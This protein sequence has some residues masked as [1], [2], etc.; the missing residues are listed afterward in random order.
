[1]Y[2]NVPEIETAIANLAAAH[3]TITE[4][5]ALPETSF[6]GKTIHC[7]RI[8]SNAADAADG[9]LF[10][11]GQHAREWVPPEIALALVADL[12]DAYAGNH[13][14]TYGGKSY[15]AAEVKAIVETVN[16]FAVPCS[17]PDGRE[18]TMAVPDFFHTNWRPNRN[19]SYHAD[20]SCHGVDLNRNYDVAFDLGKY[21]LDINAVTANTSDKPC[22]PADVYQGPSPFSEPE[23]RN[24][25]WLLDLYPRLRWLIDVHGY[26]GEIYY[27]WGLDQN[28]SDDAAMNW[29][30][31]AFDGQRGGEN[32]AYR[33]YISSGD[34][35]THVLLANHL[36]DGMEPVRGISY[37]VTQSFTFYP[38]CG[39]AQD[40]AWSRHFLGMKRVESFTIEIESS[41]FQPPLAEKDEVV[42]EVV[43]G[44]INFCLGIVCGVPQLTATPL[45]ATV[46]FNSVPEGRIASRPVIL[47]VT[48]CEGATFRVISGPTRTN[49]DV[50]ID[51]G[52]A[53]GTRTV[54]AV[55]APVTRDLFL[56]LTAQGGADGDAAEGTVEVEC[57]ETGQTW[58]IPILANFVREPVAGAVLVLDRS[59]SMKANGGDGR[60][61]LE[62]LL[63]SAPA[64]VEVAPPGTHV[65]LVRFASDESPGAPMT[66]F[67]AE[68]L[69]PAGRQVIRD[70]I[71][72]HTLAEGQ[73]GFTSIGDG[74]FAGA[75]LIANEPEVEFKALVVLTDG[76]EN[77]SRY[78]S[79]IPEL[80]DNRVFAIGLGEPEEIQP[81]ALDALTNGTGGYML[82]TGTLD[83]DDPYRLAKYYLQ[84][85]TGVTN[86]QVVLD[87]D[88]WLPMGGT[89]IIPFHLNE[90]DLSVD[91]ILLIPFPKLVRMRLRTPS[92][93][94][95]DESSPVVKWTTSGEVA[96]YR[97][98]LPVPGN[99][100][101]EGAGQWE[102]VLDWGENTPVPA[103]TQHLGVA[104]QKALRY[105]A[106]VHARS[107][108]AMAVTVTQS[109]Q[110]PGVGV[111][112]RARLTQYQSIP[113]EGAT[114][115]AQIRF[116]DGATMTRLLTPIG[117]GAYEDAFQATQSGTYTIGIGAEGRSLRGEPFTREAVRTAAVW[118]G[119][120]SQPPTTEHDP[121]CALIRCLLETKAVDPETWKRLGIDPEALLRC[122][123]P[124]EPEGR[125]AGR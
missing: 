16:I 26:R 25:K 10:L 118:R 35:A 2:H 115:R 109:G 87:P 22:H 117:D 98:T 81:I 112:V 120:D 107:E 51:F 61:R 13:D 111:T 39:T 105:K 9:A 125:F 45:T 97:F 52:I 74:V 121:W 123:P 18:F 7:L 79:E 71:E 100:G 104:G 47:Q 63:D 84:I 92:G 5:I 124:D 86:D 34:L 17:N 49:G 3:P 91:A 110:T 77:R 24:V 57:P 27:P 38:T 113:I 78:L 64:F 29:R 82:M 94:I 102:I 90:A 69:D 80:I 54:P 44:L 95:L 122:C 65:G 60:T 40:Y 108:L 8:G 43:S 36:R 41:S 33:E 14:L 70:A 85:L 59:E 48:G 58:D 67:G 28:Q 19:T 89:Q 93:V 12:L 1:M 96:F 11:F 83:V 23:T 73:A 20:P 62:V 99:G 116:P 56:W 21:F 50:S 76:H 75:E 114:V 42:R 106:L 103:G 88:G 30:N 46:V 32:D 31:P 66:V 68:G 15:T 119:G 4:L 53:I 55:G 72:A 101:A 6:D 37:L